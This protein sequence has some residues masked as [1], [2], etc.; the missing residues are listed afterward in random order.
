MLGRIVTG[1]MKDD[2]ELFKQFMDNE[3]FKRW[4][5]ATVFERA[6]AHEQQS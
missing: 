2:A 1:M 6:C 3:D 4:M 5:T